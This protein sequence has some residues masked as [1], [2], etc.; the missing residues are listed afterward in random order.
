MKSDILFP[1][2]SIIRSVNPDCCRFHTPQLKL[3]YRRYI[4]KYRNPAPTKRKGGFRLNPVALQLVI[5][6]LD[7]GSSEGFLFLIAGPS[8]ARPADSARL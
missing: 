5:P 7:P 2:L 4:R 3:F 8:L 1:G 6:E